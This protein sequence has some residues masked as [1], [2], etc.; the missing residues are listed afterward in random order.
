MQGRDQA[1]THTIWSVG[2]VVDFQGIPTGLGMGF[3]HAPVGA[4]IVAV[5]NAA[6]RWV[7]EA[8]GQTP[9]LAKGHNRLGGEQVPI[10]LVA[11]ARLHRRGSA[12]IDGR[13]PRAGPA[14]PLGIGMT[15]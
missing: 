10:E 4:W 13:S 14:N 8:D 7:V 15:S 6:Q 2:V 5:S 11:H 1:R 9:L 3:A 12:E